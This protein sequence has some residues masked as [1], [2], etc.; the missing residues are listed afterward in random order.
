V[1]DA[2]D[3]LDRR[4]KVTP[5]EF[6]KQAMALGLDAAKVERFEQTCRL[7]YRCGQ[8]QRMKDQLGAD[9]ELRDLEA[10]DAQ[11][12]AFGIAEWCEYDLGIVRGLAYYTGTVFEIHETA[13]IERAIAGGGRYDK[14]IELFDGPP[15]PAVGFGMGD[16]V[17]TNVL[18]DKGLVPKDVTPRPDAFVIAITDAAAGAL[19]GVVSALRRAGLHARMSYKTTRNAG[20]LLKDASAARAVYAVLLDDKIA[21]GVASVKHLESGEQRDVPLAEL[22]AAMRA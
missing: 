19:A 12:R 22:A 18:T 9:E 11:L 8:L 4:D 3:L 10:L 7:K 16:V 13:G 5:E 21:E 17:L 6:G 1:V 2:F 14:L 15:T 20:K